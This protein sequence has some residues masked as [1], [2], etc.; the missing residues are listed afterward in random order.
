MIKTQTHTIDNGFVGTRNPEP[1]S[2]MICKPVQQQ[3][4]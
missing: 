3:E 1:T 2:K 4:T